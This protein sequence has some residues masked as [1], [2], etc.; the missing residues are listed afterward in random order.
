MSPLNIVS[1][2][3]KTSPR[4]ER[5]IRIKYRVKSK[6]KQNAIPQKRKGGKENLSRISTRFPSPCDAF[7][8][9]SNPPCIPQPPRNKNTAKPR[10]EERGRRKTNE[11]TSLANSAIFTALFTLRTAVQNDEY[12]EG[13]KRG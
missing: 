5:S 8:F 6:A 2:S 13:L 12:R 9:T 1:R 10:R 7:F 3:S 4:N 11:A